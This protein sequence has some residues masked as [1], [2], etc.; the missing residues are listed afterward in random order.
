MTSHIFS[1]FD[2]WKECAEEG[3]TQ[4]QYNLGEIYYHGEEVKQDYSEALK[5]FRKAAED[6][7]AKAQFMLGVMYEN[8]FGVDKNDTAAVSWY[9]KA[10][11]QGDTE[12]RK[13]IGMPKR[14]RSEADRKRDEERLRRAEAERKRLEAQRKC[15][16]ERERAKAQERSTA[17]RQHDKK[18]RQA[19]IKL[20]AKNERLEE[21]EKL[22]LLGLS[23]LNRAD[24]EQDY[25][26]AYYSTAIRCFEE[27][28]TL[29]HSEAKQKLAEAKQKLVASLYDLRDSKGEKVR[30]G[31]KAVE[32][33]RQAARMGST[34]AKNAL[35]RLGE[36]W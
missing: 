36:S 14:E 20:A 15:A 4:A 31:N 2:Y 17:L 16:D 34:S 19:E 13:R 26:K 27:A 33:L 30:D 8:G 10:A 21:A 7:L 25:S 5:W 29:G 1:Q 23:Y 35:K 32:L 3:N 24:M 18:R 11:E 9:L 28:A 12:A 22:Y 6:G